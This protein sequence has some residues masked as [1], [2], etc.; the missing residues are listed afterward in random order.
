MTTMTIEPDFQQY[1]HGYQRAG[2]KALIYCYAGWC[3]ESVRRMR[4]FGEIALTNQKGYACARMDTF[5]YSLYAEKYFVRTVPAVLVF[6][7]SV[8]VERI[9]GT[10]FG[11]KLRAFLER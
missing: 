6:E 1:V 2:Q 10:R 9:E 11:A 8:L 7:D 3:R 5:R 4:D